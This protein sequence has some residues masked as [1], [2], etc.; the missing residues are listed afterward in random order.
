MKL[1]ARNQIKGTVKKIQIGSVNCEV[2]IEVAP[3]IEITSIITKTSFESLGIEF[4]KEVYVIVKA[5][6]VIIGID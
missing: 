2:I 3:G 1:S 5:S 6:N 4:G